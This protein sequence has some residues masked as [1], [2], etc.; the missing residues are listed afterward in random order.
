MIT[1]KHLFNILIE[2]KE[3]Y[4]LPRYLILII[5]KINECTTV[6]MQIPQFSHEIEKRQLIL[7]FLSSVISFRRMWKSIN[8][9]EM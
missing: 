3:K 6:Q 7:K 9:Q 8:K 1:Y 2:I 4:Y 5:S